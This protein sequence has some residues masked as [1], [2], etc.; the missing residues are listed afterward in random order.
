M[1]CFF[2]RD[3][4]QTERASNDFSDDAD[5]LCLTQGLW[6]G[7]HI[8]R[9]VVSVFTEHVRRNGSDVTLM[10]RRS[11]Y[12]CVGPTHNI[13]SGARSDLRRQEP[14]YVL[15]PGVTEAYSGWRRN[16]QAVNEFYFTDW[17]DSYAEAFGD[18]SAQG[19]KEMLPSHG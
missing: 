17:A 8:A 11:W 10:D 18:R 19:A 4:F 9:S 2:G 13:I 5:L 12:A 3:F 7:Q 6:P 1:L 14:M 15:E 16:L